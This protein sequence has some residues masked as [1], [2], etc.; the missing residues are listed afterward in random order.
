MPKLTFI[1]EDGQEIIVPLTDRITIGSTDQNDVFVDD[2]RVSRQH[3]ELLMNADGSVQVFDLKSAAGTF[4]NGQRV[5]SHTLLHGDQLAFGPLKAVLDLELPPAPSAKTRRVPVS[6][7]APSA[8]PSEELR[9][10]ENRL[11]LLEAAAKQAEAKQQ[12]WLAAIEGLTREHAEK[13]ASLATLTSQLDGKTAAVANTQK[14]LESITTSLL[15]EENKLA[16]VRREHEEIAAKA[17][18]SQQQLREAEEQCAKLRSQIAE[19]APMEQKLAS[20]ENSIAEAEKRQKVHETAIAGLQQERTHQEQALVKIETSLAEAQAALTSCRDDLTSSK[21]QVEELRARR[22]ELEAA[23]NAPL[24]DLHRR[25]EKARGELAT[26]EARLRPLRD[27]KEAQDRR[28]AQLGLLPPNSPEA[29]ELL[30]EIDSE[31][32]DLLQIVNIPPSRTP[33]VVQ[34]EPPYFNGVPLKSGHV[35][36]QMGSVTEGESEA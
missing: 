16:A 24:D 32:A 11:A 12:E 33:R 1:L 29:R 13:S 15:A 19:L 34:V 5:L 17:Q 14:Q 23:N 26:L 31:A 21:Q 4:V 9:A 35:R 30:R 18:S 3:A 28:L 8:I 36:V 2:E 7:P 22:A 20:L 27:W 6:S 25:I 10:A